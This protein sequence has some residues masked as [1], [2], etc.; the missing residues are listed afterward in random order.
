MYNHGS[1]FKDQGSLFWD[2]LNIQFTHQSI[3]IEIMNEA[4]DL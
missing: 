4:C 3:T 2:E 1:S